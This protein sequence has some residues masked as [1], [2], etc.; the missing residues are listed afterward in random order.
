MSKPVQSRS[1]H[2]R[3]VVWYRQAVTGD[4]QYPSTL[5]FLTSCAKP[6]EAV[7][8]AETISFPSRAAVSTLGS[9]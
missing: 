1:E 2:A 4:L 8:D 3:G 5:L 7:R 6:G 9:A